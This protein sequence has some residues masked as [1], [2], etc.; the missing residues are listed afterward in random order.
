MV[1][2][3]LVVESFQK[4]HVSGKCK[5]VKRD[6]FSFFGGGGVSTSLATSNVSVM[7]KR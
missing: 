1:P 5:L 7:F 2:C 3:G 4:D 6:T